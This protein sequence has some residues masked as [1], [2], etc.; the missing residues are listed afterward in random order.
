[1]HV[2]NFCISRSKDFLTLLEIIISILWININVRPKYEPST[3]SGKKCKLQYRQKVPTNWLHLTT[4]FYLLCSQIDSI[5]IV[6]KMFCTHLVIE[7][8]ELHT[9]Y[10]A[11]QG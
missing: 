8:D 2:L 10:I 5:T 4:V 7:T 1:M 6:Y 3:K 9:I 11:S